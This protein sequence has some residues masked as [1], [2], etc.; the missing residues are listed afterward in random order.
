MGAAEI[1]AEIFFRVAAFLVSKKNDS[2][3]V[4]GGQ[5]SD[6]SPIFAKG[7]VSAELEH[8]RC[9]VF[10]VVE[11]VGALGM[12]DDLDSLPRGEVSIN[13][14]PGICPF[15]LEGG[16][17][18]LCAEF[19]FARKFSKFFDPLFQ[20]GKRLFKFEGGDGFGFGHR[21]KEV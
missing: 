13:L 7:P 18:R 15:F 20:F 5:T 21:T 4:E 8:V 6:Q 10:E 11:E 12:A 3:L 2:L 9:A 14:A 19:L 1:A 17:F 16:D